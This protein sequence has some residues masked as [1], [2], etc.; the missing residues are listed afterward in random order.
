MNSVYA[1]LFGVL[2]LYAVPACLANDQGKQIDDLIYY[3][4]PYMGDTNPGSVWPK[5]Q[6]QTTT[7]QVFML[8]PMNFRFQYASNSVKCE[9]I[10]E[11]FR[12][13]EKIIIDAAKYA[14]LKFLSPDEIIP[15]LVVKI[16]SPCKEGSFPSADMNEAYTLDVN[17]D[18]SMLMGEELWGVLRGLETFSQLIYLNKDGAIVVNKTSIVDHPRFGYR[19][20]MLDSA[21]HYLPINVI[22]ENIDAMAYNKFNVFHWHIVDDQ[23][24]PFVS[25]VFPDL[26]ANGAFDPVSHIYTPLDVHEI[27][28][29]ARLRGIRVIPEFDSPGHTGSWGSGQSGLLTPC[30][31]SEKPDGTYGPIDPTKQAN[32]D[33]IETFF[34]EIRSVFQDEYIHLGGDEVSFNCWKSNPNINAWM[35]MSNITGDYAKLEEIYVQKVLN[36]SAKVGFNYI[37]WQEVIDN[38]CTV[39]PDTV[40]EIWKR[41]DPMGHVANVTKMGLRTIISQ[42]WYLNYISYGADWIKYYTFDPYNFNGTD[43]QKKLV[44]GGEA[45]MWSEYVDSTNLTPRMW[46]RASAVAERLWSDASVTDTVEAASRLHEQRCRLINRNIPAEPLDPGFCNIEWR[47]I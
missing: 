44:I 12:R 38:G 17:G 5:P 4:N 3:E 14:K 8:D 40:V 31:D 19:G 29:Y 22:K 1:L 13:Y 34:K 46:P 36:I 6:S 35:K 9:L 15:N 41:N 27:I 16:N 24:F 11:A 45:C 2:I 25:K 10:D 43:A 47:N 21:R 28:Q 7:E 37:I 39:N 33:F 26:S 42:P 32:Y 30:Y 18:N 20:V 23:S